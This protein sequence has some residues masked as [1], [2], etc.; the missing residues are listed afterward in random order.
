MLKNQRMLIVF[1]MVCF[2]AVHHASWGQIEQENPMRGKSKQLFGPPLFLYNTY[3]FMSREDSSS[4]R[5]DV[6][7]SFANDILQFVKERQGSYSASYD[8]FVSIFDE[9]GNHIR[10]LSARDKIDATT[11][12][13]TNKQ[14]LDNKHRLS[15]ELVPGKYKLT[16]DLT[17]YDTQKSLHRDKQMDIKSFDGKHVSMSEI[18]FAD[19]VSEDSLKRTVDIVPNLD[20]NFTNPKS[21][22]WAYFEIYSQQRDDEIKVSYAI[23][24]VA[25]QAIFREEKSV[26]GTTGIAPVLLDLSSLVKVPGRYSIMVQVGSGEKQTTARAKFS[27]N[28]SNFEITRLNINTAILALNEYIPEKEIKFLEQGSDSTKEEWF[29][30]YWKQRDPT[31]STEENELQEEFFRRVDFTNNYFT[32]NALDKE[33][34]RT[35]RGNIYLKYGPPTDV[36]RHLDELNLPP[37][38]IWFYDNLDRTFVFEDKSGIG[39]FQLVRIE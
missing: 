3:V 19:K 5:V 17:D 24:D 1:F 4:C 31:P 37:Y 38:E 20:R 32:V 22:F 9:K 30:Q 12:E 18:I 27:A 8:L 34:W 15:F 25:E 16:L 7:V 26:T 35:D 28:W 2:L 23:F 33:G 29:R 13:E 14:V 11:F 21:A 39:D 6:Y 10:E 36:E